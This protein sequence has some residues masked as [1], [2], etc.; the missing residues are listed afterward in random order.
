MEE[1]IQNV[2]DETKQKIQLIKALSL[3]FL[4]ALVGAV[5]WGLIY[6]LGWFV[7]IIA[8]ANAFIMLT[9]FSKFCPNKIRLGF[10]WTIC[11]SISFIIVSSCA[12]LIVYNMSNSGCSFEV[13]L[14][15]VMNEIGI[16]GLEF[17]I[18]GGLGVIFAVM[19]ALSFLKFHKS[20]GENEVV[21]N[22][23][24]E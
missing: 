16:N 14:N 4:V 15:L 22:K 21:E 9:V 12:S 13:A 20:K 6:S 23:I 2:Q 5:L 19:G 10:V 18:N 3:S 1:N 8:Y 7:C 24:N 11:W 17:I